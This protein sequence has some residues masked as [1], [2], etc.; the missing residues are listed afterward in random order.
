MV[1]NFVHYFSFWE[2]FLFLMPEYYLS[3]LFLVPVH[4]YLFLEHEISVGTF[5]N[6]FQV[7][8]YDSILI[9]C[10]VICIS[11]RQSAV[12]SLWW[13][14]EKFSGSNIELKLDIMQFPGKVYIV[15]NLFEKQKDE[16]TVC[17]ISADCRMKY[18]VFPRKKPYGSRY[19]FVVDPMRSEPLVVISAGGLQLESEI[20]K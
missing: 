20:E 6:G 15:V 19:Y 18:I 5:S 17:H 8:F 11:G 13:S 16:K 3:C 7:F 4:Q 9:H 12:F 1:G 2:F 10:L 14:V